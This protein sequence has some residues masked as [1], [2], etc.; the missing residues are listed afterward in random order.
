MTRSEIESRDEFIGKTYGGGL[1]LT[2]V[3]LNIVNKGGLK[4]E[5]KTYALAFT[6]STSLGDIGHLTRQ[7]MRKRDKTRR[8]EE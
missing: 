2:R 7:G 3:T 4:K 5:K 8:K 1:L 6:L